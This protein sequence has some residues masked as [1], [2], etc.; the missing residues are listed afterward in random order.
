M[1]H[2]SL[3]STEQ[4]QCD[5]SDLYPVSWRYTDPEQNLFDS[6]EECCQGAHGLSDCTKAYTSDNCASP[7]PTV[8]PTTLMPSPLPSSSEPTLAPVPPTPPPSSSPTILFYVHYETGLCVKDSAAKKPFYI[9]LTFTDY[10]ECCQKSRDKEACTKNGPTPSPTTYP[11]S[12]T[13]QPTRITKAPVIPIYYYIDHHSGVCRSGR[14]ADVPYYATKYND[15]WTCCDNSFDTYKCLK[16]GPTRVPTDV[17]STQ[18]SVAPSG[19]PTPLKSSQPSGKPTSSPTPSPTTLLWKE[20]V[21]SLVLAHSKHIL[22]LS[23]I[24]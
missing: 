20:F 11:P 13:V 21:V 15:Y 23:R 2:P 1:W 9:T 6:H 10:E 14:S 16:E 17:P 24:F 12:I 4:P 22:Y 18:P 5:F 7:M 19:Q 8:S 3:E